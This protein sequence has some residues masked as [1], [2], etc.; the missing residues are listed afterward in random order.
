M[1]ILFV[2]ILFVNAIYFSFYYT[3]VPWIIIG[4][5]DIVLIFLFAIAK[6][7]K[8]K[9]EESLSESANVLLEK[10]GHFYAY[11]RMSTTYGGVAA[12]MMLCGFI[13]A[14]I[15]AFQGWWWGF[16]LAIINYVI[17]GYVSRNFNPTRWIVSEE[18]VA[19]HNEIL[20]HLWG[21]KT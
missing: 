12:L 20:Q 17:M 16:G 19:A 21:R 13:V 15:G 4:G 14:S 18:D 10:Y 8:F 5:C 1:I 3:N 9:T 7:R 2:A 6:S 11:P